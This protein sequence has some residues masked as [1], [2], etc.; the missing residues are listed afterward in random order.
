MLMWKTFS[1]NVSLRTFLHHCRRGLFFCGLFAVMTLASLYN[2]RSTQT[3]IQRIA[4]A[5]EADAWHISMHALHAYADELAQISFIVDSEQRETAQERVKSIVKNCESEIYRLQHAAQVD[6]DALVLNLES[7][8]HLFSRARDES[9]NL[10][11]LPTTASNERRVYR[12]VMVSLSVATIHSALT[13]SSDARRAARKEEHSVAARALLESASR[14][15]PVWLGLAGLLVSVCG[16]ALDWQAARHREQSAAVPDA[17]YVRDLAVDA[18]FG[19]LI[20]DLAGTLRW[21]NV[22]GAGLLQ[23]SRDKVVGASFL[24]F[25]ADTDRVPDFLARL[26]RGESLTAYPLKLRTGDGATLHA[27]VDAT[28]CLK[29]G[30]FTQVRCVLQDVTGR[31]QVEEA[32]R[33][34]ERRLKAIVDCSPTG[35]FLT[36]S[37]GVCIFV[38]QKWCEFAGMTCERAAGQGWMDALHPE[39]RE[40]VLAEWEHCAQ[41]GDEFQM[42]YR[43]R[44][45]DGSTV[46]VA[47][48][49]VAVRNEA[50]QLLQYLGNV[51]DITQRKS[52][53]ERLRQSDERFELALRGSN[54][55]VWDWNTRTDEVYHSPRLAELLDYDYAA[56]QHNRL[57]LFEL[58]H[59][60]DRTPT[61]AALEAH[62]VGEIP[63][64][65][66]HRMRTKAGEYCWFHSRGRMVRDEAGRPTRMVGTMAD[67]TSQ[68]ELAAALRLY[69]SEVEESRAR[70]E[71]QASELSRQ[72]EM[73]RQANQIA[74]AASVAKGNFLANM[75]HEIRTPMTA[76]LGYVDLLSDSALSDQQRT[77][78]IAT[79]RQAG[80]HLLT[81]INDI[82]DLSKIEAG[83]L[84][85]E[86]IAM[87]PADLVRDV[88]TLLESAARC[89]G[90]ALSA[91]FDGPIPKLI[92]SDPFR[93]RQILVNLIGNALKFT[94]AG[95]VSV[96]LRAVA[97]PDRSESTL[98]LEVHDTG[99]GLT[100]EQISEL[101]R[102]FSQADVST[103]R[104]FGGTGL[105]LT[106]CRRMAHLLGGEIEVT[107][108]AGRGSVFVASVSM[109]PPDQ[110]EMIDATNTLSAASVSEQQGA[111]PQ[112][113]NGRILLVEDTLVNQHLVRQMLT[114]R[115]AEVDVADNGRLA[116]EQALK[117]WHASELTAEDRPYGV[118]LMDMQMP[119]LDGYAATRMLRHHGYQGAIVA[120]TAHA[121][122]DDRRKCLEAG[123]DDHLTKPIDRARL[124]EVCAQ[125]LASNAA[126]S[127]PHFI[128]QASPAA[129]VIKLDKLLRLV[130]GDLKLIAELAELFADSSKAQFLLAKSAMAAGDFSQLCK[131]S[132]SLKGNAAAFCAPRA[133]DEADKLER[134]CQSDTPSG[135]EET[136]DQLE[137][138]IR[139]LQDELSRLIHSGDR[140]P[141]N[142]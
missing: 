35:I 72:A 104:R 73:L 81:I 41:S 93:L 33:A 48:R 21:I 92:F 111:P 90:L 77:A 55:V 47:S 130:N 116:V 82:L 31:L 78:H 87:S 60:E 109:G 71:G 114:R 128:P 106:I 15:F 45:P 56:M 66:E 13:E 61:Q 96:V 16:V 6:S 42:E 62:L 110:L 135:A 113:L 25:I 1:S 51:T 26:Q 95:S 57:W 34:G 102:P 2:S 141:V 132:H 63:F 70:I 38:N 65:I 139:E 101:F 67:I 20:L 23:T 27:L 12:S 30:S 46:W 39:D 119:E 117:V 112:R 36:D 52:S 89:K 142:A 54:D 120:L 50:G 80:E 137:W 118:I 129:P 28:A 86:K 131:V 18:P 83:K 37:H 122:A 7:M 49:A 10:I 75:S 44:Q 4:P 97:N 17:E 103:T 76:I 121:M 69:V 14:S 98:V 99:I 19:M 11:G 100:E 126:G 9:L 5:E 58:L 140:L 84:V 94:A 24:D 79:I 108:Q 125:Y 134:I 105:G 64:D 123:C 32:Y 22:A 88:I 85:V 124:F 115:G 91:R 136:L 133:V 29:R 127:N 3:A 40:G 59:P 74:E 138:E 107:S 53:E 8:R 43:Y 68:K